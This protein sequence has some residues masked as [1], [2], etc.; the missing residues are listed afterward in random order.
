MWCVFLGIVIIGSQL[1][2]FYKFPKPEMVWLFP[3]IGFP[4]LFAPVKT[5]SNAILNRNLDFNKMAVIEVWTALIYQIVVISLAWYGLGVW[6]FAVANLISGVYSVIA[7]Y[8]VCRWPIGFSWDKNY[9]MGALKFGGVFTLSGM[10]SLLRDN[11]IPLLGVPVFGPTSAGYLKWSN[12]ISDAVSQRFTRV[13]TQVA[14]PSFSRLQDDRE[15]TLK[16][17]NKLLRYTSISSILFL[18][19]LSALMTEIVELIFSNKWLPA[20]FAF[21]CF[22]IRM[23]AT[24]FT[25]P[26]DN[27][28]KGI[29]K[30]NLSL[31]IM[32]VWTGIT[33]LLTLLFIL[34]FGFNGIAIG[35]AV[36]GW[37]AAVWLIHAVRSFGF[38]IDLAYV[39]YRPLISALIAVVLILKIKPLFGLNLASLFILAFLGSGIYLVSLFALE[40]NAF[41]TELYK[42]FLFLKKSFRREDKTI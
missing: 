17:L 42:D 14:F 10:T 22:A 35:Y 21:Y 31:K 8:N 7:L 34:F 40:R 11:I 13:I 30:V 6:S 28:I 25:T 12:N 41:V 23:I 4:I 29:G 38:K 39:F 15:T 5:V 20:I 32:T 16:I 37:F 24:N 26:L 9:L 36:G 1:A 2:R 27:L 3:L 33:W 19:I 18:G